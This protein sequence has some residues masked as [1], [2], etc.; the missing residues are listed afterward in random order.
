MKDPKP[1]VIIGDDGIE[2]EATMQEPEPV[3][4][5]ELG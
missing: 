5:M 2:D 4:E 1:T 3:T